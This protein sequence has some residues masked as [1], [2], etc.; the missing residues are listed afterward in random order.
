MGSPQPVSKWDKEESFPTAEAPPTE[1]QKLSTSDAVLEN[2]A[3]TEPVSSYVRE[4]VEVNSAIL[5]R[6]PLPSPKEPAENSAQEDADHGKTEAGP[7]NVFRKALG[8]IIE[9]DANKEEKR[10]EDNDVENGE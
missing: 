1:E 3:K 6:E 5:G 8:G 4:L 10:G 2:I 9:E 7:Q